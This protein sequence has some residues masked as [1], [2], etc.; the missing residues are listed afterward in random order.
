MAGTDL[1]DC[2]GSVLADGDREFDCHVEL[3]SGVDRV[4]GAGRQ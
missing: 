3:A 1:R 4:P 2:R